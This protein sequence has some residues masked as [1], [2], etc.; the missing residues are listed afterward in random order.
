M[1]Y[2]VGDLGVDGRTIL[3]KEIGLEWNGFNWLRIGTDDR[4]L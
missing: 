1:E 2:H 3:I 4:L